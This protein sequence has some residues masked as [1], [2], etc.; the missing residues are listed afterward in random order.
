MTDKKHEVRLTRY[1]HGMKRMTRK[2][3]AEGSLSLASQ[4]TDLSIGV[5][6]TDFTPGVNAIFDLRLGKEEVKRMLQW[7]N[8]HHGGEDGLKKS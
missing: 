5:R 4:G 6:V 8:E 1:V 3:L 7:A 2:I